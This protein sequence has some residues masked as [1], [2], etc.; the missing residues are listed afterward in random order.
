MWVPCGDRDSLR[1]LDPTGASLAWKFKM[2]VGNE[3]ELRDEE[4]NEETVNIGLTCSLFT[5]LYLLISNYLIGIH[6]CHMK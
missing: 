4:L 6:F 3:N 1:G 2:A 5:L